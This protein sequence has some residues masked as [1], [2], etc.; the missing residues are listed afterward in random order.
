MQLDLSI[1]RPALRYHGSK[2][3]LAQWIVGFFPPHLTYCEPYGGGAGVLIRKERSS[4]E[5]YNDLDSDVVNLFKV[6]RCP[7]DRRELASQIALTPF[8]REEYGQ[9]FE[10]CEEKIERARRLVARSYM[11]FGSH[12]HNIANKSN[13]F[14]VSH[15]DGKTAF[16]SYANEW[17]GIPEALLA[18]AKRFEAVTI[19]QLP[20]IE[21]FSKYD[22]PNALFY[23]DPPYVRGLRDDRNK[24]YAC[25]MCDEDH[26]TLA[27]ALKRLQGKVVIS[28][29]EGRLY[30][31]LFSSWH[32]EEKETL[33]NGQLGATPRLEVLW[34]NYAPA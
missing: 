17:I 22:S 7:N 32:R 25:E 15:W 19:E 28:G 2:F 27:W 18:V 30:R 16:K 34:M 5:I 29:Y 24:G 23:V 3:R 1:K 11:G 8:S 14:R 12:S 9:C 6:L 26:R 33:A 31:D 4:C 10:P 20:A 21:I 13:G